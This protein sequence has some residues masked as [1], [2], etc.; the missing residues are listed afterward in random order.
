MY[1]KL[2]VASSIARQQ[3]NR[4]GGYHGYHSIEPKGFR[5][6]FTTTTTGPTDTTN[7][8]DESGLQLDTASTLFGRSVELGS[9]R[10]SMIMGKLGVLAR[11]GIEP[12]TPAF[13]GPPTDAAN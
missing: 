13:S 10:K 11:D 5:T 7:G 6:V 9:S 2:S 3:E 12:P 1:R 4:Q 8:P